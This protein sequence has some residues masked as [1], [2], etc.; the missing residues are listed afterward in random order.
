MF[1]QEQSVPNQLHTKYTTIRYQ[2]ITSNNDISKNSLQKYVKKVKNHRNEN[3]YL[4]SIILNEIYR[5]NY[6]KHFQYT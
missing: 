3:N 2:N 6:A 1:L 4:L 5:A